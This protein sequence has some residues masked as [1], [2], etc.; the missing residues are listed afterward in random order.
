[1]AIP[2]R[3]AVA[4]ATSILAPVLA[5]VP[6][7]AQTG[8]FSDV[9]GDA[10]YATAVA[11]LDEMGVFDGT[12]A[13]ELLCPDGFCPSDPIDRKTMAVWTVRIV[14]GQ[15]PPAMSR[16]R[17]ADVKANSFYA[18]F[19]ERMAQLRITLGCG[20]GTRFC[21]EETVSRAQMAV[22]I[23]RAYRLADGP[24]PGFS[25]VPADAW[26]AEDVARLNASGI[27]RGCGDGTRFCPEEAT[28]R[29][30][31]ATFLYRARNRD[32]SEPVPVA[33]LGFDPSTTPPLGDFDV[34]RLAAAAKTLDSEAACPPMA[35]P[36]SLESVAEVLRIEGGC[37]IITYVPLEGR[38]LDELRA[39]LFASDPAVH[40]VGLPPTGLQP[41]VLQGSSY[42]G[43]PPSP[44]DQ[45]AYSAGE[46]WH[47]HRL[48]ADV[49]WDPEGWEYTDSSGN[50]RRVPGWGDS[51]VVVAVL[52]TGT[53]EHPDLLRSLVDSN[54]QDEALDDWLD[55]NCHHRDTDGHGTHVAGLI[56]AE[57]GNATATT[58]I[59]PQARILP[60]NLLGD[61]CADPASNLGLGRVSASLAVRSARR[62]G[63]DVINMSFWWGAYGSPKEEANIL[64]LSFDVFE[65]QLRIAQVLGIVTVSSAG[66]CGDPVEL[67]NCPL[68]LDMRAYP[69][70]YPG[71]LSVAATDRDS[72]QAKFSTSNEDVDVA[73]P[74]DGKT[75]YSGIV[76]T[77]IPDTTRQLAGTSMAAPLV[78]GVV[79]HI[80]ARY[81]QATVRE[82]VQ[83]L[84]DTATHPSGAQTDAHGRSD[85]YGYGRI[86][87][88]AAIQ[89]LDEMLDQRYE[90]VAAG[91]N[92]SCALRADGTI[93]CWG[94]NQYGKSDPPQGTFRALSAGDSHACAIRVNNSIVCWGDNTA[95]Q[96]GRRSGTYEAVSADWDPYHGSGHTCAVNTD[97]AVRCWG[98]SGRSQTPATDVPDGT[99][100]AVATGTRHACA[101]R[102]SGMVACWGI[103]GMR[104]PSEPDGTFQAIDA[105]GSSTC[106]L[107][108][109]G[110][111]TCWTS[112]SDYPLEGT[113]KA[114]TVGLSGVCT[115]R[116]DDTIACSGNNDY[117]QTDAPDGTFRAVSAG[118]D[119][120]CAVRTDG[121][122]TC[123]GKNNNGQTDT[124]STYKAVAIQGSD[125]CAIRADGT[126]SCFWGTPE[127]D[128]P[129]TY[130]ALAVGRDHTCALR[131]VGTVL[132][133]GN[134]DG[135]QADAPSGTYQALA[136]SRGHTCA[137]RTDGTISC[138]GNND[139]GQADAPSGTHKAISAGEDHTCAL[140]TDGTISCWGN[141]DE[142]QADAPSGT[143]KAISAGEDHTC[144]L[145]TDGTIS[146][147]GSDWWRSRFRAP[148]GTF[149]AL[150]LGVSH[151]TCAIRTS[152]TIRCWGYR[153]MNTFSPDAHFD[154]GG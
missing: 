143:H 138:W 108:G 134:N 144:A 97:G 92:F 106:G 124:S 83:S 127:P 78:S 2:R 89:M 68:G 33:S 142:G 36:E 130:D 151:G 32:T 3:L 114:V 119:H 46:W 12:A 14:D 69:K 10:Y 129:G 87:P 38:T 76:S 1:M 154:D 71:V 22:F 25:D 140:R 18:P 107:R 136:A 82:I 100:K 35:A 11:Q 63:A 50:R 75:A 94:S 150:G 98:R 135:R 28:T 66:N 72:H 41:D 5:V 126:I 88:E 23:A 30:Q 26:Y 39:E 80:K 15:D 58:G 96:S 91:E 128:A 113:H 109:N 95:G 105:A 102:T 43:S 137:L 112:G 29:A 121:T 110:T 103:V 145:R 149:Q 77:F 85:D 141:N 53:A 6:A 19:V 49:L 133:W 42:D 148:S 61:E 13:D 54:R 24:D 9:P 4:V 125:L 47:L 74:G 40:A 139:E 56:A 153:F 21:P 65:A 27:T 93:T 7:G 116:T 118:A 79:A 44:Y 67:A 117:G 31:M 17:F 55:H 84:Q 20:D 70:A 131:T 57:Y 34:E 115:I 51:E 81:P 101:I 8:P 52:D 64:F 122:I 99:Y 120:A 90:A 62:R 59:A 60:I 73:A 16:P 111:V 48:D 132:C 123:W 104:S 45:D 147:W 146:C 86:E 37:D 152:G